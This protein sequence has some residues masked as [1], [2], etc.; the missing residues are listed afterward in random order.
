MKREFIKIYLPV[1]N[2][3]KKKFEDE[4]INLLIRYKNIMIGFGAENEIIKN[5]KSLEQLWE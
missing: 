5:V 1:D 2:E 4:L 3:E